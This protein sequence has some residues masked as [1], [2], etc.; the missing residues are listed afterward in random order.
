ML[1]H[2]SQQRVW[3]WGD[4]ITKRLKSKLYWL[5]TW[6]ICSLVAEAEVGTGLASQGSSS[7]GSS[8]VAS[9]PCWPIA[10]A[11]AGFAKTWAEHET[12]IS[13][14]LLECTFWPVVIKLKQVKNERKEEGAK[15]T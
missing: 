4:T 11:P 15:Y 14:V 8:P 9:L 6:L 3:Q 1:I 12:Q 7:I 13:W 2:C 10:T 5:A